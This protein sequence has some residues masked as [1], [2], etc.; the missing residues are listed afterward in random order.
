MKRILFLLCILQYCLCAGQSNVYKP[1]CKKPKWTEGGSNFGITWYTNYTYMKD[2]LIAGNVYED[3]LSSSSRNYYVREDSAQKKVYQFDT[4]SA[5]EYLYIDFNL[6][7]GDTFTIHGA[8]HTGTVTSKDS[9]FI[10]G[11]YHNQI[12]ISADGGVYGY[13][14]GILSG[15]DPFYA[16]SNGGDPLKALVCLCQN[17]VFY[18]QNTVSGLFTCN[19]TCSQQTTSVNSALSPTWNFYPNPA[20]D[21]LHV[22]LEESTHNPYYQITNMLGDVVAEGEIRKD[23][24]VSLESI[25]AGM[26]TLCL[27]YNGT[28]SSKKFIVGLK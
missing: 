3:I 14:E 27:R 2:T 15:V 7:L 6:V 9:V 21:V 16:Y 22:E 18:Y 28:L 12:G 23:G 24:N 20:S 17:N 5:S 26:Y 25:P 8:I 10:N 1:F 19:L 11:S 13:A 4:A